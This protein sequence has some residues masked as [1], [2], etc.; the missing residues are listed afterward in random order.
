MND[1]KMGE[2]FDALEA[3]QA[4][5]EEKNRYYDTR[6]EVPW[7]ACSVSSSKGKWLMNLSS[8]PR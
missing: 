4:K 1:T 7:S 3:R 2:R 5:Q 6:G 8:R